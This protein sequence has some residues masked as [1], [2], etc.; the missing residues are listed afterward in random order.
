MNFKHF[1]IVFFVIVYPISI[2]AE[3]SHRVI[4]LAPN[5]T[6]I[7]FAIGAGKNMVGTS[8]F[9]NFPEKA[10]TIPIVATYNHVDLERIVAQRSDLVIAWKVGNPTAEIDQLK[11]IGIKVYEASFQNIL[12]IAKEA[13]RFGQLL[14]LQK[15]AQRFTRVFIE[16][17]YSMQKKYQ[18]KKT[19][20]VFYQLSLHPLMTLN[21]Q[22]PV[23][24]VIQLCGGKN[25]FGQM[26]TVA[27]IVDIES[28]LIRNPDVILIGVGGVAFIKDKNNILQFWKQFPELSAVKKHHIYFFNSSTIE[29]YGPRILNGASRVCRF[30]ASVDENH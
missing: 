10:K 2:C 14:G 21:N 17:Y 3:V 24:Q 19:I 20:T 1:W 26:T 9:S 25:I 29:R 12:D 8:T 5:I 16:N 30:M 28:V 23:G 11:K 22:S 27:P 6:E 7:L 15:S 4:S 13:L 18:N